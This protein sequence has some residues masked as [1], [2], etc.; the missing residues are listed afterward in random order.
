MGRY[1]TLVKCSQ[2]KKLIDENKY[3][4]ALE[5][6]E[7]LDLRHNYAMSDLY[8]FAEV[9]LKADRFDEAKHIY[10]SIYE[11]THSKR[12]LKELILLNLR[13]D[14]IKEAKELFLEYELSA[15]ATLD[16][17]ELR[18]RMAKAEGVSYKA[19]IDIL[20]D[21]R[22]EEFT[23]E[24]GFQL[25]KLYEFSGERE[26]CIQ[27]CKDIIL[28]FGTGSIVKKAEEL[29]EYCEKTEVL[30]VTDGD[31]PEP[32]KP[33]F[34]EVILDKPVSDISNTSVSD[35]S[36]SNISDK[37]VSEMSVSYTPKTSGSDIKGSS[38]KYIVDEEN[39]YLSD[40]GISYFTLKDTIAQIRVGSEKN[41]FIITGGEERI[42]TAVA[43]KMLKQ[44][45]GFG[46]YTAK[47]FAKITAEKL[48]HIQLKDQ[49]EKLLDG[50]ILILDAQDMSTEAKEQL[51]D[52][53]EKYE[54]RL[55]VMLSGEFDEMDAWL[56]YYSDI[57]RKFYYKVRL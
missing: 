8:L 39:I 30:P 45:S 31:I 50:C 20:E 38:E 37:P 17:Y 25:A 43:K 41:N 56:G 21:L 34:G 15:N 24:W 51:M 27:V 16:L 23:E 18:Y 19:L 26:K 7:S 3:V 22:K 44:L 53:M 12:A 1:D 29:K 10:Y 47:N 42:V 14:E 48:N 28:W 55:I 32:M 2:I 40:N 49:L 6:I 54:N 5:V 11:K 4:K 9:Y 57:E 36:V 46:Y 13:L 33:D 35:R 52:I